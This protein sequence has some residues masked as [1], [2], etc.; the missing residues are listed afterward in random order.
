[1]SAITLSSISSSNSVSVNS[2]IPTLPLVSY[3]TGLFVILS[4]AAAVTCLPVYVTVVNA[5][6]AG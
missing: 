6:V 4:D 2:F 5:P 1:M 3:P